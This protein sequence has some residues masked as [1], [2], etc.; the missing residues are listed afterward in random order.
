MGRYKIEL[1]QTARNDLMKISKSGDQATIKRVE[2]I[3][4]ELELHPTSGSGKPEQLRYEL[5]GY[6]SRRINRKDRLIY[7]V[8][9]EEAT[10]TVLSS[11]GHY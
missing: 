6:W 7:E 10:V 9:E 11:L 1:K 5:S 3:F 4:L 2:K 8:N